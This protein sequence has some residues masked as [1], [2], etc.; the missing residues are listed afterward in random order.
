MNSSSKTSLRVKACLLKVHPWNVMMV[1]CCK[2][3]M[4]SSGEFQWLLSVC[5]ARSII[6]SPQTKALVESWWFLKTQISPNRK[7]V[8][9]RQLGPHVYDENP[10]HYFME[11][12]VNTISF[13]ILYELQSGSYHNNAT[14]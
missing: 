8:V 2:H 4:N 9:R 13:H 10:T 12:Q 6:L 11:T 1:I 5:K 14:R 7:E 3:L